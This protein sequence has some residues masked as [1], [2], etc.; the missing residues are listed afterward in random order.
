MDLVLI[1]RPASA[2]APGKV[3]RSITETPLVFDCCQ[4][5]SSTDQVERVKKVAALHGA[6]APEL[7][8]VV[9]IGEA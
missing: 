9:A 3:T 6:V 5:V 4:I 1:S 7:R 8:K 2:P